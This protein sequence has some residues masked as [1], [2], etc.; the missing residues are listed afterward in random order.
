VSSAV[1]GVGT[2]VGTELVSD[3]PLALDVGAVSEG[4]VGTGAVVGFGAALVVALELGVPGVVL[5][6]ALEVV[7]AVSRAVVRLDPVVVV[8]VPIRAIVPVV[9]VTTGSRLPARVVDVAVVL[10]VELVAT[11]TEVSASKSF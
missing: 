3:E 6:V 4:G 8:G 9:D 11:G 5:E 1:E 7:L 10:V 2:A